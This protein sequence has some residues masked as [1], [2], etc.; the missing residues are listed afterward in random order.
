M[1]KKKKYEEEFDD[2]VPIM[3]TYAEE[4]TC[5]AICRGEVMLCKRLSPVEVAVYAMW[6]AIE[7]NSHKAVF[8]N[9][10]NVE[11]VA[12]YLRLPVSTVDT[13]VA[14]LNRVIKEINSK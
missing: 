11:T 4:V 3:V 14:N 1:S 8:R 12:E 9:R 2:D 6:K 10:V 5:P 7:E 13:A